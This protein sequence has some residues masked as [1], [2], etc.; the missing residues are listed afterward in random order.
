MQYLSTLLRLIVSGTIVTASAAS[1]SAAFLPLDE[2]PLFKPD[3]MERDIIAEAHEFCLALA[4]Y[5]EGGSTGETEE[6]Q[7]HIARV[8]MER[9]KANKPKWGGRDICNVVFYQHSGVCQFS[10]A[11]L[12]AARR[13]ARGG[14]AWRNSLAI[15]RDELTGQSSVEVRSIRYYM[16][17]A[18]TSDRNACRF[19]REFVPVLNAGRHEF[20][21]EPTL[22][23]R[24][25]IARAEYV[26]CLRHAQALEE[27]K[28][29][30]AARKRTAKK[31]MEAKA[32]LKNKSAAVSSQKKGQKLRQ[33]RR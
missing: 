33:A 7:R 4:V 19:R 24:T 16:N 2:P 10:F 15:A 31:R 26:E 12:P 28:R 6:G 9:A 5:F 14:P 27:A 17:G 29:R 20:F 3:A 23:E 30:A 1:A 18:L 25:L 11:C 13:T 32:R 22:E 21:R 8:V